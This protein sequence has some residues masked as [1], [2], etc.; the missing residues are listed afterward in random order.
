MATI[1]T[2][3]DTAEVTADVI[4][5]TAGDATTDITDSGTGNGPGDAGVTSGDEATSRND[6]RGCNAGRTR[7]TGPWMPI[8]L[9]L[10]PGVFVAKRFRSGAFSNRGRRCT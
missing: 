1:H 9:I 10:L 5:E 6:Q 4:E 3:S 2:C 8:L 7:T